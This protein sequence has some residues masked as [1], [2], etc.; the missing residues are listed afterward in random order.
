MS[1]TRGNIRTQVLASGI[2]S[3]CIDRPAKRNGITPDMWEQ[4]LQAYELLERDSALRVG[5]LHAEGDHFTGGVDLPAWRELQ[6]QGVLTATAADRIDPLGLSQRSRSKPVVLAVE[7][8]C[9]TVGVEL[10]LASDV[11]V[12]ASNARFSQLEVK[13]G[14]MAYG[15][16]TLRMVQSAGWG[17]AMSILLTGDEFNAQD[18]LRLGFVQKIVAPGDAFAEALRIAERIAANAPLAVAATLSN[19]REALTAGHASALVQM[20]KLLKGLVNSEDAAEGNAAF[21]EKRPGVFTGH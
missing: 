16:A 14:V 9:Y 1:D 17:N 4:M 2:L 10:M 18:A 6:L 15:G 7:G 8:I 13:R 5:L 19:A 3:I 21:I 11:T 12:A 20:P